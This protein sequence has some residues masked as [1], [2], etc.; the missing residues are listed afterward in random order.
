SECRWDG[1]FL[2][3]CSFTRISTIPEDISQTAVTADLSYNNIKTFV[4]PDGRN[5]QWMLKHLNLSNNK[6]CEFTLTTC[7]NLPI[8]ETLNLNGNAI[9]TLTLDMPTAARGSKKYSV[10]DHLL[11]ALKVLSVERNNLNT[12]PK[13]LGLLQSLQTV[14]MSSNAI[15]QIDP[16]DF[17][18]CS[19]LKDIDLRNNKITKIH[20]DAF[21]DLN[22]LQVVVDLRENA[23]TIPLPQILVSLNFFQLEVYLS[24]NAW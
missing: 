12:V 9:H 5:E 18:N 17:Q 4:C 21:R 7:T 22:K 24:Q 2:L 10:V 13:G 19:Q 16:K 8:L 14:H 11:P 3:N 20:P 1:P 23:L 15:Q 6:I